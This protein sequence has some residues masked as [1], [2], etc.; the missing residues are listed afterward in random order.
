MFLE[1]IVSLETHTQMT[2]QVSHAPEAHVDALSGMLF[3]CP[4]SLRTADMLVAYSAMVV[5]TIFGT[6]SAEDP[7]DFQ[8]WVCEGD[9]A[10]FKPIVSA[11]LAV[12]Y[13]NLN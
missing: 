7:C 12:T 4:L 3:H 9:T 1:T 2:N 6:A 11:D 8:H 13:L 5:L 10:K